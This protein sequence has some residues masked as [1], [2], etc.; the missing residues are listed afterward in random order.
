MKIKVKDKNKTKKVLNQIRELNRK[1]ATVGYHNNDE[2]A[3]IA[4]VQE[5]GARIKVTDKMRDYLAATGMPLKDSTTEIVIPERSFLRTGAT[6]AEEDVQ[7]LAEKYFVDA[8]TGGMSAEEFLEFLG[9][10]LKR[11]IQENAEDVNKPENHP[12]TVEMK[13]NSDELEDTGKMLKSIE[14]KVK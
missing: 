4:G 11:V 10:E 1:T 5:F 6:L 2:I 13:G 12:Y 8:I 3:M 7:K 14:V 9:E